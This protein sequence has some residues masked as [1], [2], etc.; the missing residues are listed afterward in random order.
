MT[1]SGST[2]HHA[3]VMDRWTPGPG[4][5][6]DGCG[7][8]FNRAHVLL[9]ATTPTSDAGVVTGGTA[10]ETLIRRGQRNTPNIKAVL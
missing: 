3:S 6:T 1:S 4:D 2:S 10:W 9:Q 8:R 7:Y 5:I